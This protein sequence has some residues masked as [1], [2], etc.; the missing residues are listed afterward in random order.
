MDDKPG[1]TCECEGKRAPG[2]GGAGGKEKLAIRGELQALAGGGKAQVLHQLHPPGILRILLGCTRLLLRQPRWERLGARHAVD[3]Q[4]WA[5][6]VL[7]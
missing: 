3:L 4:E 5:P 1:T 7:P 6:D 2:R